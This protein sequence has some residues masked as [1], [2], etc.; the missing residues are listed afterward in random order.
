[1]TKVTKWIQRFIKPPFIITASLVIL[2]GLTYC[3]PPR[4]IFFALERRFLSFAQIT[5]GLASL[6]MG[7]ITFLPLVLAFL[8]V[9]SFGCAMGLL[10]QV[11]WAEGGIGRLV[12]LVGVIANS[13]LGACGAAISGTYVEPPYTACENF[14][15]EKRWISIE[16]YTERAWP[17]GEHFFILITRDGGNTWQQALYYRRDDPQFDNDTLCSNTEGL[18]EQLYWVWIDGQAAITQDG[19]ETWH[20]L[21]K[22]GLPMP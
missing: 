3:L 11:L 12:L 13:L 4:Y 22:S 6:W 19:G 14:I 15:T 9:I 21:E 18:D 8:V 16:V 17:K 7:A 10:V 2:S 20:T 1:M 5:L